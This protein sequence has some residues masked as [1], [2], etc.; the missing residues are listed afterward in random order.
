MLCFDFIVPST[1]VY[2]VITDEINRYFQ[3][4]KDTQSMASYYSK[5]ER[6]VNWQLYEDE[7]MRIHAVDCAEKILRS[8]VLFT[9][10]M[11][12]H[13]CKNLVMEECTVILV[14]DKYECEKVADDEYE[15]CY[16]KIECVEE[17]GRRLKG[18]MSSEADLVGVSDNS[19]NVR[20]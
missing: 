1:D 8:K 2:T 4:Y 16:E 20:G 9:D 6:D 17:F 10:L 5:I 11:C 7:D 3:I 18:G 19:S 12:E 13:E 15:L 14:D